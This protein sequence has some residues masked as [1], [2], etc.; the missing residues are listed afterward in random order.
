MVRAP[1]GVA[2]AAALVW[3]LTG[4]T[5]AAQKAGGVLRVYNAD[6]PPGLNIYEQATP[7]GQGPLMSVYNNLILF[8]QHITQN[9]LETFVPD[10]ASRWAWNE[11]GRG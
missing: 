3:V 5:A 1:R 4:G 9:S 10:L 2:A 8:D 7:W 6:S 11:D